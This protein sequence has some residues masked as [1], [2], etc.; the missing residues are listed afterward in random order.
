M[1]TIIMLTHQWKSI[2]LELSSKKEGTIQLM[3]TTMDYTGVYIYAKRLEPEASHSLPGVKLDGRI[4]TWEAYRMDAVH[5][6]C[7][8]NR[9]DFF[10]N[11][12]PM[13]YPSINSPIC[14]RQHMCRIDNWCFRF[15]LLLLGVL[16]GSLSYFLLQLRKLKEW[17]V[18]S[19]LEIGRASCRERVCA[20]V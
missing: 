10:D 11:E 13:E 8:P 18:K 17:T 7:L 9:S 6:R 14:Q 2:S 15:Y 16:Y 19:W 20:I 12:I 3:K 4:K 1:H 5:H